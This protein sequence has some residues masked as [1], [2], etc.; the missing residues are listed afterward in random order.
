MGNDDVDV[1]NGVLSHLLD[2]LEDHFSTWPEQ[3]EAKASDASE[4]EALHAPKP[5]APNPSP[6][7]MRSFVS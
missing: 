3:H 2:V 4:A 6:R 5:L 1:T 7:W